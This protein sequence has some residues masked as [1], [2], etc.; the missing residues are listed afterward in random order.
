M[1]TKL[2]LLFSIVK[3]FSFGDYFGIT[4]IAGHNFWEANHLWVGLIFIQFKDWN[5]STFYWFIHNFF[6]K[7]QSILTSEASF[8]DIS[9]TIENKLKTNIFDKRDTFSF[10]IASM[11]YLDSNIPSSIYYIYIYRLWNFSLQE[12]TLRAA[13]LWDFLINF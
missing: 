6:Y 4:F 12:Q 9:I 13:L 5:T 8:L 11:L 7:M 10:S 2:P 1:G 3:G